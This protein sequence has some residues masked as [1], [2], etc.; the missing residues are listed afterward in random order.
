MSIRRLLDLAL[1]ERLVLDSKLTAAA[2]RLRV[3]M[4]ELKPETITSLSGRFSL[5]KEATRC[6][7]NQLVDAGW[8]ID[9]R[10]SSKR[11]RV[12][13]PVFPRHVELLI[14][15]EAEAE[16][17]RARNYGE[18][19]MR[20][21]CDILVAS[22]RYVDDSR[23]DWLRN[24]ITRARLEL[25]REYVPECVALEFQG[26]QHYET[27]DFGDDKELV[28]QRLRDQQKKSL[29]LDRGVKLLEI[30]PRHLTRDAMVARLGDA[31]PLTAY[32]HVPE[33]ALLDSI[34]MMAQEYV[35]RLKGTGF[36]HR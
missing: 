16:M 20:T 31:L 7:I 8:A 32:A 36:V 35:R 4:H 15:A 13:H 14:G 9:I 30:L 26:K 2:I 12:I 18:W 25:D 11:L 5:G 10:I 24:L 3:G 28:D 23:P 27:S 19:L 22:T 34:D 17:Q 21:Y 29:C 1:H 6:A 33:S